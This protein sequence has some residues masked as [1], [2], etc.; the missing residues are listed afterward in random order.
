MEQLL[1]PI[2][3]LIG[4]ILAQVLD[5]RPV[6]AEL[7]RLHGVLDHGMVDAVK[8][9]REEQQMRRGRGQPLRDIAVNF[10]IAGSTL[11]PA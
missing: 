3:G 8:L 10:E 11:S 1:D 4:L 9:E 5:P 6:M 7:A 2:L